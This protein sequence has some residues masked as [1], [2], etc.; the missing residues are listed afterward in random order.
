MRLSAVISITGFCPGTLGAERLFGYAASEVIG[1]DISALMIPPERENEAARNREVLAQ[2][3]AV[4]DFETTCM[5][6]GGRRIDV[7]LSLSRS[8]HMAAS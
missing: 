7:S 4:V 1:H 8:G 5:V 2:G 6:K 3:N